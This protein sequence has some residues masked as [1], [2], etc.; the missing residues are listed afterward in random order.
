LF[1][2]GE[3]IA[4]SNGNG[5]NTIIE[6]LKDD[7]SKQGDNEGENNDGTIVENEEEEKDSQKEQ[8]V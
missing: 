7:P 8:S 2:G 6:E 1:T 5:S 3:D 4:V